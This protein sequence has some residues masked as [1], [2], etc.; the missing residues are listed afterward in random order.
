M[1][2]H[3]NGFK[4]EC[5]DLMNLLLENVSFNSK[6]PTNYFYLGNVIKYLCRCKFKDNE[7]EDLQKAIEYL[8]YMQKYNKTT[9]IRCGFKS[10]RDLT[11]FGNFLFKIN[12]VD[13]RIYEIFHSFSTSTTYITDLQNQIQRLIDEK[14]SK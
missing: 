10:T 14:K 1:V 3:Y 11:K 13:N 8:N 2:K 4:F 12:A 9:L 5:I 7:I 6:S